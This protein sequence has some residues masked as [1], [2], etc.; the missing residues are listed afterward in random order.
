MANCTS[1]RRRLPATR[2][3]TRSSLMIFKP[4]ASASSSVHNST[5]FTFSSDFRISSYAAT[6][7]VFST[8][9]VSLDSGWRTRICFVLRIDRVPDT[10]SRTFS[11]ASTRA[12]SSTS[13][14]PSS[15]ASPVCSSARNGQSAKCTDSPPVRPRHTASASIGASGAITRMNAS[16]T[17]YSVLNAFASSFQKRSRLLR[18]YQLVS[19]SM[20]SDTA[21]H[22]S[23]IRKSSS[24]CCVFSISR[25][26]RASR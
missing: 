18:M 3:F 17:V 21:S 25:R 16:S 8:T 13:T 26:V 14:R 23:E 20:K 1:L 19:M 9:T 24:E 7:A 12:G 5:F 11:I 10:T 6:A 15:L 2:A 22:A 4:W